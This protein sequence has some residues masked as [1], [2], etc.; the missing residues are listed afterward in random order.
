MPIPGVIQDDQFVPAPGST[1][2]NLTVIHSIVET[3]NQQE[4]RGTA[5]IINRTLYQSGTARIQ[6]PSND[7]TTV[8]IAGTVRV[9]NPL[10][11][12]PGF[13]EY[14]VLTNTELSMAFQKGVAS[15]WV[16]GEQQTTKTLTGVTRI[17][18]TT[19]QNLSGKSNFIVT[20]QE[21]V[22]IGTAR[23]RVTTLQDLVGATDIQA[24]TAQAQ[25][26]SGLIQ[27][28][29]VQDLNGVSDIQTTT[30][31]SQDGITNIQTTTMQTQN[32]VS[33]FEMSMGF[34]RRELPYGLKTLL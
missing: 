24:T 7:T 9:R 23:I 11:F 26:G 31:Q 20:M 4:Q 34:T 14:P 28:T 33:N 25:E 10:Q 12:V 2:E 6:N 22:V 18:A 19:V 16:A 5:Y 30:V 8:Y 15:I 21:Q 32:G 17:Q 13:Q 3:A 1:P 29:T 27:I